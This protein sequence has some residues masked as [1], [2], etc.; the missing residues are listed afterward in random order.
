M[1]G[2]LTFSFVLFSW[3]EKN[4]NEK[5]KV[6]ISKWLTIS[7]YQINLLYILKSCLIN[8]VSLMHG[9]L[10]WLEIEVQPIDYAIVY[11]NWT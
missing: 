9:H 5:K 7:L 8:Y 2:Q 1:S 6:N 11:Q 10:Q 3:L 4:G